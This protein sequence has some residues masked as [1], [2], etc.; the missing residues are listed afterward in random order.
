MSGVAEVPGGCDASVA[1]LVSAVWPALTRMDV[2][3]DIIGFPDLPKAP[4]LV[5]LLHGARVIDNMTPA[6][7]TDGPF[8]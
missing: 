6:T 7:R 2:R 5:R 3:T 1:A 4:W 8:S